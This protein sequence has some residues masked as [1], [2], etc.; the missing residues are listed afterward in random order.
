MTELRVGDMVKT[1]A[2]ND[3]KTYWTPSMTRDLGKKLRIEAIDE[4]DGKR[5]LRLS[6]K[7]WYTV[8][9]LELV[10]RAKDSLVETLSAWL[11][12]KVTEHSKQFE[13]NTELGE[14]Y[15]EI[16][17]ILKTTTKENETC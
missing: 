8:E 3:G 12:A 1:V 10:A 9:C 15:D 16:A 7:Y 14:V 17:E 11:G 2:P 13:P 6:N 5:I 4:V